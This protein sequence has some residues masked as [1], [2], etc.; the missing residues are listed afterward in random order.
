MLPWALELLLREHDLVIVEGHKHTAMPVKLWLRS[1]SDEAVPPESGPVL[2]SMGRDDDRLSIAYRII[3]AWLASQLRRQPLRAGLLVGGCS[4]RMGRPKQLLEHHGKTWAECVADALLVHVDELY[5]LGSGEL[6]EALRGYTRLPDVPS[7]V[8]PVA[9]MLAAMRWAPDAGWLFAACDMPLLS[10][11][12]IGWLLD[13]RAPGRWA[14]MPRHHESGHVEP[15][16][17]WY[18]S[19][20]AAILQTTN[21]PITLAEHPNVFTPTIPPDFL[22]A[23]CNLNTPAALNNLP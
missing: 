7:A 21:R 4:S 16:C 19:R 6:P 9:G 12:A 1:A 15:L 3:V 18:D 5:L 10:A 20:L 23:W 22:S 17:A 13:Q 11:E 14:V 2:F 8:G